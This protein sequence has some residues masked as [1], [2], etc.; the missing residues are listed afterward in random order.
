M[1]KKITQKRRYKTREEIGSFWETNEWKEKNQRF[2]SSLDEFVEKY[3]VEKYRP[4]VST[5]LLTTAQEMHFYDSIVS[6]QYWSSYESKKRERLY[7]ILTSIPKGEEKRVFNTRDYL[8]TRFCSIRY[9]LFSHPGAANLE[10]KGILTKD[11]DDFTKEDFEILNYSLSYCTIGYID[12]YPYCSE[13]EEKHDDD[14]FLGEENKS[15][16]HI[17]IKDRAERDYCLY[18]HKNKINGKVYVGITRRLENRWA[19]KGSAYIGCRYFYSAIQKYG[20]D[21]FEHIVVQNGLT[22]KEA[23]QAEIDMISEL[24]STNPQKGYNIEKGGVGYIEERRREKK[25]TIIWDSSRKKYGLPPIGE[26]VLD[27]SV[28]IWF[29]WAI[30]NKE[31]MEWYKFLTGRVKI[32][33]VAGGDIS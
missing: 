10:I 16:N 30:T 5:I 19:G 32:F 1:V 4:P 3:G 6:C 28:A 15:F 7:D 2:E 26:N 12:D 25:T 17:S 23:Q 24:D 9:L 13:T 8:R 27:R 22:Q 11:Y 14:L 18:I 31:F 29:L 33:K 21:N 20:W